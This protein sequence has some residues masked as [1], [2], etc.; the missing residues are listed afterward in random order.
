MHNV[1]KVAKMFLLNHVIH[2]TL[3]N[4]LITTL[5]ELYEN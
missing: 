4:A 3:N 5:H 2:F 1:S